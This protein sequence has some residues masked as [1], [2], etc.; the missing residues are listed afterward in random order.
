MTPK[1][2]ARSGEI[3]RLVEQRIASR[4]SSPTSSQRRANFVV[5]AALATS[6]QTD[7]VSNTSA[8]QDIAFV[9]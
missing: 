9:F 8:E 3:D 5:G 2:A 1:N 4:S 7:V 6:A